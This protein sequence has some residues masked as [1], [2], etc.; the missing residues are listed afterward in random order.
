MKELKDRITALA[1]EYFEDI[2]AIRRHIHRFPE[3]SGQEHK[4]MTYV[5]RHLDEYGIPYRKNIAGTGVMAWI[6]GANPSKN[7]IGIRADMDALPIQEL[8]ECDYRSEN[9][10]VMHACGHDVHTACLLGAARILVQLKD[11]WEGTV[12]LFFQP[13]E[14]TYPGGAIGMIGEGVL[15]NPRPSCVIGQHVFPLLSAG[16][17]GIKP[18]LFMAST[19]EFFITVA[20]RGGHGAMPNFTIDPI[21]IAS[22]IV[23]ALQQ[24][25]SRNANPIV[26]TVVTIGK[27]IGDGRTNVIPD[28]V[29]LEGT[30]RTFD[31]SWRKE[32][33]QKIRS[34]AEG[35]ASS[36]GG[37]AKVTISH[38]YP[39]VNNDEMLSGE[40]MKLAG[41][42]LGREQ[43]KQVE[44]KMG[45][46][47]FSYFGREV[48]ACLFVL[49]IADP[50]AGIG[51][52]LHTARFDVDED[53]IR[54][55]TGLLAWFAV[56]LLEQ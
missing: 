47:D 4:T 48:P 40:M 3:L 6:G 11:Q 54:T 49:G 34:I 8:N 37:E 15:E 16:Q 28:Q 13:S 38:G 56:K 46:E 25:A 19:D 33:Q 14:E 5:C 24:I 36:M 43:V 7:C 12:K 52:N 32:V 26:P 27:F 29:R 35:V 44:P 20:G 45:A 39:Y 42:Y 23:V 1:A 18:G 22:Y 50:A 17:I 21:L 53:S 31:E 2:R 51:P 9:P 55:G 10:G 41:E 30:L